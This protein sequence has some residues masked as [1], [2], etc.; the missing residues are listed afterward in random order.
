MMS[1]GSER[2]GRLT[3]TSRSLARILSHTWGS[4]SAQY[5]TG[6]LLTIQRVWVVSAAATASRIQSSSVDEAAIRAFLGEHGIASDEAKS[7]YGADGTYSYTYTDDGPAWTGQFQVTDNSQVCV[8]FDNGSQRC[9][10][11]VL[12]GER[13]VLITTDGLR[14]PVRN[15][16]VYLK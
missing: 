7:R 15:R 6:V 14:F 4:R 13:I 16:S 8:E 2:G 11:I 5:R 10:S 3:W 1:G 9:D 12:D